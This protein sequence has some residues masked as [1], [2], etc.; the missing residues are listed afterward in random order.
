MP[1]KKPTLPAANS[2]ATPPLSPCESDGCVATPEPPGSSGASGSA[3]GPRRSASLPACAVGERVE[4][5]SQ[6]PGRKTETSTGAPAAP[7]AACASAA[8]R[9]RASGVLAAM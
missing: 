9:T 6:P 8:S 5:R 3:S 4:S 7:A 1:G 2:P